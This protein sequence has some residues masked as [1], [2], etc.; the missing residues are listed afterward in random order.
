MRVF[1]EHWSQATGQL[2]L[3][4][5]VGY[6]H[7]IKNVDKSIAIHVSFQTIRAQGL[8]NNGQVKDIHH[9]VFVHIGR[10]FSVWL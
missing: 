9:P 10:I 2:L 8:G 6:E 5:C 3:S 1:T 4:E 7:Q